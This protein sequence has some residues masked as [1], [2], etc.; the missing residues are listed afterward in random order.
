MAVLGEQAVTASHWHLAPRP[1]EATW[2]TL[3]SFV[4]HLS[5][6]QSHM[7]AGP[8]VPSPE[9]NR[10]Q[11]RARRKAVAGHTTCQAYLWVAG[12]QLLEP[13]LPP[14]GHTFTG[15]RTKP[16]ACCPFPQPAQCCVLGTLPRPSQLLWGHTVA[17]TLH[18]EGIP[19]HVHSIQTEAEG[20][21]RRQ[22][23]RQTLPG[24]NWS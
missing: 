19:S 13:L 8:L 6:A 14:L 7:G 20:S 18:A 22:W 24:P 3:L 10:G 9:A 5:E 2:H 12:T 21:K 11:Y 17:H 16:R 15:S 4:L 23:G 1:C